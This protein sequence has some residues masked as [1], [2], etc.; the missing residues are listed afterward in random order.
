MDERKEEKRMFELEIQI[1]LY[2]LWVYFGFNRLYI[3]ME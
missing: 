1:Y 3:D 2:F